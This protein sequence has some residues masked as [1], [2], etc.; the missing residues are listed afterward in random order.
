[1]RH[2]NE[3]FKCF[4]D[5]YACIKTQFNTQV[6]M[7]RTDNGTEYVND[8]FSTFLSAEGILHQTSCPGTPPQN[9]V[10]ERKNRHLLEIARSLMFTMN[11]PKFLWSEAVLTATYL[12]NRTP[13][14]VL[15][16]KTPYEMI[17]GR[18]EFVLPLKV[19]GCTC[20]V[21]DHIPSVGKLD[22]RAVKCIFVGYSSSQKGYKCWSPSERRLFVSMDVTF[23]ESEPF[24]GEK[25]DLST[26]FFD[27][28]SPSMDGD[29]REGE[30]E[31]SV[32]KDGGDQPRRMEITIGTIPRSMDGP[33]F[34][35]IGESSNVQ[36]G[37]V[38]QQSSIMEVVPN[39]SAS[40][41]VNDSIGMGFQHKNISKV[42][43]R[44]KFRSQ[45]DVVETA[46]V[47]ASTS[48]QCPLASVRESEPEIIDVSSTSEIDV[49]DPSSDNLPI[50]LRKG[51]RINAGVPRP[52][53]GF[54]HDI[55][56]YVSYESL[57]PAYRAFIASLQCVQIPRD[58]N[59]AKHD[60][61]WR[62][63]MLEE[64]RALEKNKT[65][66]I[67]KLP[68]GKKAVSCKWVFTVKQ[69]PEG[70]VE[71]YKARLVA[72]GYSQTYG[73]DYDET[74]AP[75][76]KMSTVRTLVSCAA[77][78]GWPLYQLDVK[79]AFLHGELQEEVYMEIPPGLSIPEVAGKV[80]KLKKSLYG[81]KQSP[82]AWFD[83]FK[84][85]LCAMKYIQCNGDHTLFYRHSGRKITIL[86]VYVDDIIIT[87]DDEGEIKRLKEN[88]SKEF[89]VKD[90]GQL[91]Y[92]LGIEIARNPKGIV[93]SQ[94]KYILDLLHETGM[95]GCR[96]ASTPIDPNHNLCAKSG[97]PVNK[98]R[99]QRLVG[100]LIYLCHTRPDISYAVSV[101]SRYMHDPRSG[102]LDAVYQILRYLK[103]SPG[104]GLM[105][106]SH[107]HLNLE[108]YCD[109]DWAS[110]LDDRRSTLGYCVFVGGNLVS[111]RS[112]KQSVVSRST[113][114]AEYRAMSLVVCEM[115]WLRSLLSELKVL[116]KGPMKIWCDNMS[117]INI[118]NNPVQHDR[119]KHVEIDR[120]FI[121]EKLDDGSIELRHVNSGS[122]IA[123]SLTKGLR[124]ID[125]NVACDK[126][127][128]ID[129]YHP[130]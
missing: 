54:E 31:T 65:W 58:W 99:Y 16:M 93:L 49:E 96:P 4:K 9:G 81:L 106:K 109:A 94:R 70:K 69:T 45:S 6:R 67:V 97:H 82:R 84:R 87:G 57:S 113:A 36:S 34:T 24:Y 78:F 98:E 77:N 64:L 20:F 83:R 115:L 29:C 114:E 95:L 118:A 129:I 112:K 53:L 71:R 88:L 103:S 108:G 47:P 124:V 66:D 120:F 59:E 105:F 110:C 37:H 61:K 8:E 80:C 11:V 22:P 73:I 3:V 25:T 2:K 101:V 1:M 19:F 91:K 122:Q 121:K 21:R 40:T 41:Q 55:S 39:D 48:E 111:W 5:F 123:D 92:F 102:H 17:F 75:V 89:E 30:N 68:M 23:R 43:T 72:R 38:Q 100:R 12:I 85:A 51:T 50:A 14:R 46:P 26:L 13:S 63:A 117:A 119:T 15:E 90:L 60:P 28:D 56:N 44:R 126:M 18:N 76:A 74:F 52:R 130:S 62:E 116:R 107:G 42:Y 127:G 32:T 86:A 104:K 7:I 128:M 125:C 10:A 79:N 33:N 27:L 35:S